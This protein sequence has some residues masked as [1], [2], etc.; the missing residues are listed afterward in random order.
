MKINHLTQ[1][2]LAAH[3]KMDIM[4]TSN[5]LRTL[6]GKG[7]VICS[8]YPTDT[9]A[10]SLSIT[11]QD[12]NLLFRQFKLLKR[13]TTIF[14]TGLA[15]VMLKIQSTFTGAIAANQSE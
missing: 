3:A 15:Q 9:R 12:A 7:L 5:V 6:E 13:L 1:A 2:D 10:K 8:P 4:M 14:S 11:A